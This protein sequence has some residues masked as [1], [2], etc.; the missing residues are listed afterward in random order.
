MQAVLSPKKR[1]N[2]KKT[3][4]MKTK[5]TI[6]S[7]IAAIVIMIVSTGSTFS[8][9]RD[10]TSRVKTMVNK[11]VTFPEFA[12]S[13]NVQGV[14]IVDY[15]VEPNG[16]I[17]IN[18]IKATDQRFVSYIINKLSK[19]KIRGLNHKTVDEAITCKYIFK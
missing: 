15:S 10:V 19:V 17:L 9:N 13:E 8:Q 1:L 4:K 11:V 3:K 14:A 6:Y 18:D 12:K 7:V 5:K 16:T 2:I